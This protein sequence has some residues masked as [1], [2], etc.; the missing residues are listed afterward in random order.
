MWR[1]L[2]LRCP[3]CPSAALR[4]TSAANVVHRLQSVQCRNSRRSARRLSHRL[5]QPIVR[6]TFLCVRTTS[7]LS[8][9]LCCA[10][11]Q[12]SAAARTLPPAASHLMMT[13]MTCPLRRSWRRLSF[14][15]YSFP[16][17]LPWRISLNQDPSRRRRPRKSLWV[18]RYSHGLAP[19][20]RPLHQSRLQENSSLVPPR[21]IRRRHSL[22][23][24][25]RSPARVQSP[26]R[27][28]AL[29]QT[30]LERPKSLPLGLPLL[31]VAQMTTNL[32]RKSRHLA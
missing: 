8:S 26:R 17:A 30:S 20:R 6:I 32:R 15:L 23:N 14:R 11:V 13:K 3:R 4:A 18:A 24:L 10:R 21:T 19:Q 9:V 16:R 1:S 2:R 7:L 12:Q 31:S 5:R 25:L 22:Q 29:C 27:K 28:P